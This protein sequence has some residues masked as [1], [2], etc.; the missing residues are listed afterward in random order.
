MLFHKHASLS[1]VTV[2][3]TTMI[4]STNTGQ[5]VLI[6][7]LWKNAFSTQQL[8]SR[9]AGVPSLVWFCL[10]CIAEFPDQAQLHHKLVYQPPQPPLNDIDRLL[11]SMLTGRCGKIQD[12]R[13]KQDLSQFDPRL[14]AVI[15]QIFDYLPSGLRTYTISLNDEALPLLQQIPN[16]ATFSLMTI[17]EL[18]SCMALTDSSISQLKDLHTLTAFDASSTR[19]SSY[20]LLSLARTLQMN[21]PLEATRRLRGPWVLRILRL[22]YCSGIDDAVYATLP[23]FPLLS[24]V[25]V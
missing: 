14:W 2:R 8:C 13:D 17:L 18:P 9:G 10:Q 7:P 12:T 6:S 24:V 19:I 20:G 4:N 16:T 1:T 22:K 11:A 21:D 15:A 25:G 23:K 5:D 3:A